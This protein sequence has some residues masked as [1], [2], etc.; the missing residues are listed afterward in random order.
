MKSLCARTRMDGAVEALLPGSRQRGTARYG[1]DVLGQPVS[2]PIVVAP[3]AFHKLACDAGEIATAG[4][5]KAAGTL[6]ILS[7]LSN[8]AMEAVFAKA[9]SSSL[10]SALY[11]QGP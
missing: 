6:F 10:V 9:A 5:A 2:M 4:A 3:T 7:S 8:T 11:I 1:D